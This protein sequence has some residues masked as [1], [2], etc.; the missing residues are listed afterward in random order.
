MQPTVETVGYY[1]LSLRDMNL[2]PRGAKKV[3]RDE[4]HHTVG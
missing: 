3:M 4:F 2:P 1:Q